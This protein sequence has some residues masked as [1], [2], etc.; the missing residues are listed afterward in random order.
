[1]DKHGLMLG[2]WTDRFCLWNHS[3]VGLRPGHMAAAGSALESMVHNLVTKAT[4]L[5]WTLVSRADT[6][7]RDQLKVQRQQ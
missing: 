7:K 5:V 4:D 3:H 6:K 1:M 2:S